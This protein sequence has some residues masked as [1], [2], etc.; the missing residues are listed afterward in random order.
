[1]QRSNTR[2]FVVHAWAWLALML[3]GVS[4]AIAAPEEIQVY[5]YDINDPG[6]FGIEL[7]T[8]YVIE[9][10][11]TSQYPGQTPTNHYLQMTPE[12]S[13][14]IAKNW[15]VG[16]YVLTGRSVDGN[17]YGNGAKLR[18][19]Y[20]SAGET[21]MFWG[22]NAEYGRT[23]KRVSESNTNIEIRPIIGW[24]NDVWLVS[25]NPIIG[26]AV[27]GDVSREPSF[28]PA[29][30]VAR[31]IRE[32][33]QLGFEHYADLGGI[34]H[35]PSFNQQEHTFYGVID[36]EAKGFDINFGIGRAVT[37]GT[38]EKWVAKMIIGI[39]FK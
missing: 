34:H 5:T 4:M 14:G 9:G 8:N 6:Q 26:A 11:R 36:Y 39:P 23:S 22:L 27:S 25:F 38:P 3:S 1:M 19:K 37:G 24:R 31:E 35:I 10:P 28:S 2:Y 16:L 32:G 29:I 18:V 7:H 33:L 17:L 30:K 15:D 12:F 21:G 20:V 13:Y